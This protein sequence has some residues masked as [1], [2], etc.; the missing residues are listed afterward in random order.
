VGRC[1]GL[2][3]GGV[4]PLWPFLV[5]SQIRFHRFNRVPIL[6]TSDKWLVSHGRSFACRTFKADLWL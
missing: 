2:F 6:T 4:A 5:D 3:V 1:G